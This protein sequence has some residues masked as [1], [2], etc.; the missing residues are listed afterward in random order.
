MNSIN[1]IKNIDCNYE[2]SN[3]LNNKTYLASYDIKPDSYCFRGGLKDNSKSSFALFQKLYNLI[4]SL[5][6]NNKLSV[7]GGGLIRFHLTL[8]V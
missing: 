4:S 6:S 2:M 5:T 3:K 1:K 8:A 7:G